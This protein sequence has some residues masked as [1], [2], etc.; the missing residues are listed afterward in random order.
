MEGGSPG[1]RHCSQPRHRCRRLLG[2]QLRLLNRPSGRMFGPYMDLGSDTSVIASAGQSPV[3]SDNFALEDANPGSP[4]AAIPIR[5]QTHFHPTR[6]L[7]ERIGERRA[8]N[9]QPTLRANVDPPAGVVLE[10]EDRTRARHE[11]G[12]HDGG[13]VCSVLYSQ[14]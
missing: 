5:R 7:D 4:L 14:H 1:S 13:R 11:A 2:E 3:R 12:M 6:S 8:Q 10:V 9:I